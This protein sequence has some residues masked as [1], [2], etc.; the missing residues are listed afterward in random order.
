MHELAE[1]GAAP[2]KKK[3]ESGNAKDR[4]Q[5]LRILSWVIRLMDKILHDP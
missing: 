1:S 4:V 2:F 3:Q 5:G